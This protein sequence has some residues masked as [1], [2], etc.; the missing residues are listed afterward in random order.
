M[1]SHCYLGI[2]LGTQGLS[3]LWVDDDLRVV[4]SGKGD[5]GMCPG[6][7]EGSCEQAP[8]DWWSALKTA[9]AALRANLEQQGIP[10]RPRAIGVSGQMHGEVLM[11][12][13]G[14]TL[15]PARLWCDGRN[16]G[17]GEELTALLGV[18]MPKRITAARWLWT[19][20]TQPEKAAAT[21][22]ITTPGGWLAWRLT[23]QRLLGVG[24]ASGMF[25][26]SQ[27]SLGYDAASL[28][29]FDERAGKLAP[30]PLGDLLP[31]VIAA[32]GDGGRVN[33]FAAA[34]LGLPEGTP[35]APAEGDQPAAMAGSLIAEPGTVGMSFGT[36]VCAN[37]VGD[38]PFQGV[39]P[40]I[41]HFCAADGRPINMVL[42]RNGTA[43]LSVIVELFGHMLPRD[44]DP[45]SVIMPLLLRSEPDCG[46]LMAL[47]FMDDEPGLGIAG[48]GSAFFAGMN[49]GNASPGNLARAALQAVLF[50][51]RCGT[52]ALARQ[53]L[54]LKQV[55][56]TG[57]L[58][59]TPE[60]G[61]LIADTFGVPVAVP[62][63]SAEGSALG[64]AL[65]ARYRIEALAGS[66]R[67]WAEFLRAAPQ[68]PSAVFQPRPSALRVLS[69]RF[70]RHKKL[71][72][73]EPAV[74]RALSPK[75]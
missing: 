4:A 26:I 51:L 11:D 45:F 50:N 64:A 46:G 54:P 34:E 72:G 25:P 17:E 5:Y 9:F 59:K 60:T 14:Q 18:K 58:A 63:G 53:G 38:R 8:E 73:A 21:R 69:D 27:A 70:E 65:L 10:F 43:F 68:P 30:R 41:D 37:S 67:S 66:P 75:D 3:A 44:S 71:L 16:E 31:A 24:D 55:V 15:G 40:G 6:L 42:L 49:A 35:V 19:T 62:A 1:S 48:G 13:S 47:P 36:S 39:H 57:G 33:S 32:G 2:D 20:R 22:H 74:A 61:Q 7:E 56:L 29:K 52:D 28:E 23:G 12:G